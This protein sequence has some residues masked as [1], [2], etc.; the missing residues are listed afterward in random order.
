MASGTVRTSPPIEDITITWLAPSLSDEGCF[1]QKIGKLVIV[2]V[3]CNGFIPAN[4]TAVVLFKL[5]YKPSSLVSAQAFSVYN[6]KNVR[7]SIINT[8]DVRINGGN[9]E[10]A[11][12]DAIRG[13][14]VFLQS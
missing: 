11:Y 7:L 10:A 14:I 8:G 12:S 9:N 3:I 5:P 4:G 1:V 13:Q 6:S 2:N